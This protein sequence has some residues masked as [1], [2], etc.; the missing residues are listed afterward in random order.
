MAWRRNATVRQDSL[1]CVAAAAGAA[2]T[3]LLHFPVAQERRCIASSSAVVVGET[4]QTTE[5]EPNEPRRRSETTFIITLSGITT[6]TFNPIDDKK[7]NIQASSSK[8]WNFPSS[9]SLDVVEVLR[10]TKILS[11]PRPVHI[12]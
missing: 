10:I 12:V 9:K 3:T 11:L 8:L 6:P 7:L 4:N 5:Q 1:H 2:A